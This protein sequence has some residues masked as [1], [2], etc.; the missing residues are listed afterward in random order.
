MADAPTSPINGNGHRQDGTELHLRAVRP[1]DL[2]APSSE[3]PPDG[4]ADGPP[5]PS[6]DSERSDRP[7]VRRITAWTAADLMAATFPEPRWAVP[8]LLAEGV[9][10]L[11]GPPKV[12]KSWLALGLAVAVASGGQALGRIS[13]TAGPVLYL[14]LE[15]TGRRLQSRL[16]K[17]LQDGPPPDDLTFGIDCPP[18][19][20]GGVE[21]ITAW[22]DANPIARLIIIDVFAKVR[23]NPP[24]GV[25][26]YDADYLAVGHI[27]AIA[28][29]YGVA[30][31]L[32]HHTRKQVS[33]DFLSDVSGTNGIA[34]AADATLVLR[35][36]RGTA[37]G[38]LL[39][40]G[41][42][43]DESEYPMTFDADMGAWQ[44]HDGPT[45]DLLPDTRAAIL[46]YVREHPGAGPSEISEALDLANDLVR[47]TV[48]RMVKDHQLNA[49]GRGRYSTPLPTIPELDTA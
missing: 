26:A 20:V 8:G 43:I 46:G 5:V 35:R 39:V 31:V 3:Y 9:S 21:Q 25:S 2:S 22:L 30:V 48:R 19:P 40:T 47:A 33:D 28:D 29:R 49:D 12:G 34:G 11:A 4:P 17:V 10:V 23:G 44:L 32:V 41:R 6:G 18:L 1:L 36:S 37:G 24:I 45:D 16:S 7:P 42:D 14:A 38:V 27:K 15:D 13:V